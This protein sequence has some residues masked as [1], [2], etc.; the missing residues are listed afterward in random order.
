MN[1][2]WMGF[3]GLAIAGS[4]GL[5]LS[6]FGADA[7]SSINAT[8]NKVASLIMKGDIPK[9]QAFFDEYSTADFLYT[10]DRGEHRNKK[11]F[12]HSLKT[13]MSQIKSVKS[14]KFIVHSFASKGKTATVGTT[15]AMAI[16]VPGAKGKTALMESDQLGVD[17]WRLEGGKWKLSKIVETKT[18]MKMNGKPMAM[19]SAPK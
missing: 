3:R 8:Y 5:A 15:M 10:D 2:K 7:K 14:T 1:Q 11:Q 12:L 6:S 9:L 17:T 16:T 4:L 13:G 18:T 19:S